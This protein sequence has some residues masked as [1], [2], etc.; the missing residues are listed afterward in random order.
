MVKGTLVNYKRFK[1]K[2][3]NDVCTATIIRA[4]FPYELRQNQVG[5]SCETIFMPSDQL[6]YL[7]PADIGRDVELHYDVQGRF[8]TLTEVVVL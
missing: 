6:N 2:K 3:G 7:K 8:S 5:D 1:S 4:P